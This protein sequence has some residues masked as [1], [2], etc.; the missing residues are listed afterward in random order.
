MN[1]CDCIKFLEVTFEGYLEDTKKVNRGREGEKVSGQTGKVSVR[2]IVSPG[3]PREFPL[4]V[5]F[6]THLCR[7]N[8][9]S[10]VPLILIS[11]GP[12]TC[13]WLGS[14]VPGL[15]LHGIQF[16]EAD[17]TIEDN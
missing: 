17:G 6:S 9:S 1:L 15:T 10:L 14:H 12:L 7:E 13:A 2:K 11:P 16:T 3:Q 4:L 8:T 5:I